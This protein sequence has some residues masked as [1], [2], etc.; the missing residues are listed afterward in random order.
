MFVCNWQGSR[1]RTTNLSTKKG[2][3]MTDDGNA[4]DSDEGQALMRLI[5]A[6]DW[7]ETYIILI[8]QQT[9]L[10]SDATLFIL[11]NVI[12][13]Y[14]KTGQD[15]L[16]ENTEMYLRLLEDART[17]DIDPAWERF[18]VRQQEAF[19]K[20]IATALGT[21]L[22]IRDLD[23]VRRML[24][25]QAE[26][27]R[28]EST[29]ATL[30]NHIENLRFDGQ[31]AYAE[32][33]A[34]YQRLLEDISTLGMDVAWQRFLTDQQETF[35]GAVTTALEKF[36]KATNWNEAHTLLTM[37]QELLLSDAA[38]IML[39]NII[40]YL[41]SKGEDGPVEGMEMYLH[42]L[43]DA[44]ARGVEDAWQR[45]LDTQQ[46]ATNALQE[47]MTVVVEKGDVDR[48]VEERREIL[49]SN[50]TFVAL[51]GTA[52]YASELSMGKLAEQCLQILKDARGDS[53]ASYP[54]A[55]G[56]TD[57]ETHER[58][59]DDL[60]AMLGMPG[61][62]PNDPD[63]APLMQEMRTF[64]L[65]QQQE[66]IPLL[67]EGFRIQ[68]LS[69]SEQWKKLPHLGK[70]CTRAL[71][72]IDREQTPHLWI[73]FSISAMADPSQ[74]A[75]SD[76]ELQYI[77]EQAPVQW[78]QAML[79]RGAIALSRA[80]GD[81][82]DNFKQAIDDFNAA[83]SVLHLTER[84]VMWAKVMEARAFA[85]GSS[86]DDDQKR[87]LEQAIA[88]FADVLSILTRETEADLWAIAHMGH[89]LTHLNLSHLTGDHGQVLEQ[90]IVDCSAALSVFQ[91]ETRPNEWGIVLTARGNAY[92]R[93]DADKQEQ[94]FMLA[95][96][97]F[98]EALT[99]I[100]RE[101]MPQEWASCHR[102]RGH[103]YLRLIAGNRKQNIEQALTDFKAAL[104]IFTP[105]EDELEW[106]EIMLGR[107]M[108]YQ[109][110]GTDDRRQNQEKALADFEAALSV[111]SHS[112][113]TAD[114]WARTLVARGYLYMQRIAGDQKGNL[115]DTVQDFTQAL[116]LFPEQNTSMR[117]LIHVY[118]GMARRKL[119]CIDVQS[120]Q[121]LMVSISGLME[122]V[123][124]RGVDY[125][126]TS[127]RRH[128]MNRQQH[129][130]EAITDFDAALSMLTIENAPREWATAHRERATAHMQCIPNISDFEQFSTNFDAAWSALTGKA[131]SYEKLSSEAE[132]FATM[133]QQFQEERKH[134]IEQ[135]IADYSDALHV[136]TS[137]STPFEW[138]ATLSG[139]GALYLLRVQQGDKEDVK[140]DAQA[141]LDDFD[142]CLTVFTR[143]AAPA[144]YR[145]VHFARSQIYVKLQGWA[146]AHV[147]L[148]R[149]RE[150]QRDLVAAALSS[151]SQSELIA[152][153]S[154]VNMYQRDAQ[155]MLHLELPD[156]EG[157]AIALEEGR[158]QSMRSALSLDT[159]A[160]QN[161]S[162][163]HARR[164]AEHFVMTHATWQKT[165]QD[166][167]TPLL[168]RTNAEIAE[169]TDLRTHNMDEAYKAFVQARD[170]IRKYDDPDFM[171][172]VPTMKSIARAITTPEEAIVYLAAGVLDG[173]EDGMALVITQDTTGTAQVQHILLP[174]L[175]RQAVVELF[176]DDITDT[177]SNIP[178][179]V[180][181]AVEVL[182][183]MGLNALT[184]KLLAMESIRE[185]KLI[186]YGWLG[187][188][189]LPSAFVTLPG[190]SKQPFGETFEVTL[191]PSARAAEIASERAVRPQEVRSEL[192][193]AGNP[194]PLAENWR[195]LPYADA[196]AELTYCIARK[197]GYPSSTIRYL[198][199]REATK[200]HI[201]EALKR[202]KYAHL[203]VHGEYDAAHPQ[204]S[205]LVLAG[206]DFIER[207][208]RSIM[209]KEAL[210]GTV[211]L[212]GLRLLVLSACETSVFDI[213]RAP[214]EVM[215]LA[216]GFLQAGAAGV[217]ASL[218]KVKESATYLLMSRFADLY[219]NQRHS[220]SPANALT[221]AQHWLR[222]E[223]TFRVLT[224]YEPEPLSATL[225]GLRGTHRNILAAIHTEAAEHVKTGPDMLPYANPFYW[226]AFVVT[227]C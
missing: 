76:N 178:I 27:L 212:K 67:F 125:L 60:R 220:I 133:M 196:E 134:H 112:T 89:G 69:P 23:E 190:G 54:V 173:D 164:R 48:I 214:D 191:V 224:T 226:A 55:P 46:R 117:A 147:A 124:E 127:Y 64:P 179:K 210:A 200:S 182:G 131:V 91:R 80:T 152:E 102:D 56:S 104:E 180:K 165:Q 8:E 162:D 167:M 57:K 111:F 201:V 119:A 160:P 184:N 219:L 94:N 153:F 81:Q 126:D 43:E 193:I 12:E 114:E 122:R 99:V 19:E 42:L 3:N 208:E 222:E 197:H 17:L 189:P 38:L 84:P 49:L 129:V 92:L 110:Y 59:E 22:G 169:Q 116:D 186:T 20:E 77:R 82:R 16:A 170:D 71:T 149:V 108:A 132:H 168:E 31:Y 47:L 128:I 113:E 106:A 30:R 9:L 107:G 199:P 70:A 202:V 140:E 79:I 51:Y 11:Y 177:T 215:G 139:R 62:D 174:R 93:R 154:P 136:F 213:R 172:P 158:A 217:I 63:Y 41:R 73:Q 161:I 2:E 148:L 188:L 68:G 72:H 53:P 40:T 103:A 109:E 159:I 98:D 145:S 7:D 100:G 65:E 78:V 39:R 216:A 25:E 85:Y 218:W 52:S 223:A 115:E 96:A 194:L 141:A 142:K 204:D 4:Y 28:H 66:L 137:D 207:R 58:F 130:Q 15:Y 150:V 171:T 227:G 138:A 198:T 203:A 50:F 36:L 95:I 105:D 121:Q 1:A 225:Q 26:I 144:Y 29:L 185:V 24:E 83:L 176:E 143:K 157:A 120:L 86:K 195:E 13:T 10:L 45:L 209:L 74:P 75:L 181:K 101:R 61:F 21:F 156:L 18:M 33:M 90:V 44:Q 205:R 32:Y 37:Q 35:E 192:L 187:L 14:R 123:I 211:D 146:A 166:M 135:A 97:D 183:N 5:K 155:V 34:I 88:D 6:D 206:N 118:R 87:N 151:V 175:T 163:P 221:Q